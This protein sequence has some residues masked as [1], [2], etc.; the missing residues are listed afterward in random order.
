MGNPHLSL[1]VLKCHLLPPHN[2]NAS[3]CLR[4]QRRGITQ[5]SLNRRRTN[6]TLIKSAPP[7]ISVTPTLVALKLLDFFLSKI[8]A[9][10]VLVIPGA[11]TFSELEFKSFPRFIVGGHRDLD[12]GEI[13]VLLKEALGAPAVEVVE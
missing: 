8:L 1:G 4:D 12:L 7:L 9:L 2:G 6:A 5:R 3:W 10:V 13:G 11:T